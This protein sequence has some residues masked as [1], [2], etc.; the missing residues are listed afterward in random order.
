LTLLLDDVEYLK[1]YPYGCNEQTASRLLALL[2]EHDIRA[3]L[4]QSILPEKPLR[5]CLKR[6]EKNQLPDGA[7]GWWGGGRSNTWMTAYVVKALFKTEKSG[8]TA[9]TALQNG[10]NWLRQNLDGIATAEQPS[11]LFALRECGV[12]LD[13]KPFVAAIGNPPLQPLSSLRLRQMCGEKIL[14]DSLMRWLQPTATGGLK[15]TGSEYGWYHCSAQ[16]TLLAYDIAV[17]AG[18]PDLTTGIRR[19]WLESRSTVRQRNT[20]E[21]AQILQRLLPTVLDAEGLLTESSLTINGV[22]LENSP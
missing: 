19:F 4:K 22:Q 13:C 16:N 15:A 12:N 20:I 9:A 7:W 10:L 1:D 8:F 5:E 17:D 6:L 21:I 2:A 18:L 3:F 11:A 14:R